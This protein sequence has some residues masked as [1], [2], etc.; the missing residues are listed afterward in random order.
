MSSLEQFLKFVHEFNAYESE[1]LIAEM[2]ILLC[3]SGKVLQA[4]S[5]LRYRG[6]FKLNQVVAGMRG[7]EAGIEDGATQ[8][9]VICRLLMEPEFSA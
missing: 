3:T 8:V 7:S 5:S 4:Q 2:C 1:C 9:I 6:L